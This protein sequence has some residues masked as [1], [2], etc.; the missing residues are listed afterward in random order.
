MS[1]AVRESVLLFR[2]REVWDVP[3][4]FLLRRNQVSG[5]GRL[6]NTSH[7]GAVEPV[8]EI[9]CGRNSVIIYG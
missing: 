7:F 9:Y 6:V 3:V 4:Y 8:I 1:A 2:R 5:F